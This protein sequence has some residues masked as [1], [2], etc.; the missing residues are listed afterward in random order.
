MV[1]HKFDFVDMHKCS[2]KPYLVGSFLFVF[3]I[4]S[5]FALSILRGRVRFPTGGR[6]RDP[7]MRLI[8]CDSGTDSYS[9]DERRWAEQT[10]MQICCIK[11]VF[12]PGG[13]KISRDFFVSGRESGDVLVKPAAVIL[14]PGRLH[15]NR[16]I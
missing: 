9:L 15:Q 5:I 3:L 11:C 14:Y 2:K 4:L 12:Y 6:V 7:H 10:W 8:R 16:R 1:L 13:S